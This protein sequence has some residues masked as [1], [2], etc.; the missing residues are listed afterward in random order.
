MRLLNTNNIK[1]GDK[2]PELVI[3]PISR[4]SLTIYAD[5][6]GDHNPKTY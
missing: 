5:A 2:L 1:V 4:N 3:G 6:S